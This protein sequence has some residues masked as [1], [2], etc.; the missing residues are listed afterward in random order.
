[1]TTLTEM[2]ASVMRHHA[3]RP[4]ILDGDLR[5]TWAAFGEHVARAAGVLLD[6]GIEPGT[7]FAIYARS[8][9]RFETLRWAGF[10][11]G[12]I[13]VMVNWRL[14]PPEVAHILADSNAALVAVDDAFAPAF[15]NEALAPWADRLL[16]MPDAYD[17]AVAR[18]KP[19]PAITGA[20]EDDDAILYYTGGTT[21]RSKGVRLSH[22][23]ILSNAVAFALGIGARHTDTYL[24]LAPSFHS[25]DLL[26]T[27]WI[28]QGAAQAYL[29][30]FSPAAF[31]DAIARYRVTATV[32]VPA[33]LMMTVT[34]PAFKEADLSSL[35]LLGYGAAPMA[36]EWIERVAKAFPD[37]AFL[38]CYG[39]TETAPDLTI[40]DPTE[41]RAA[42]AAGNRARLTS[43]GKPS[44][45]VQLRVVDDAGTDVP[46]GATGELWA[47]GPNITKGYLN[48][49]EMTE[50]AFVDG[51]FRTGDVAR[52]DEDGYVH[53]LDRVKDMVITGGENV[54]SSEVEAALHRHPDV[55]EAAVIGVPD[56]RMGEAL[57]A[58]IVPRPDS[59]PDEAT[60]IE[61]CRGLIAGYKI[62]RRMAFVDALPKSAMG[63]VLKT[64]L[65]ESYRNGS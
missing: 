36:I 57:L 44:A 17:A 7:R 39:L 63:K 4:A 29:A 50:A 6:H 42:I 52:F 1:M 3:K 49:P 45:I 25:A 38:N 14:A 41:F 47:K 28:V 24:H 12:A 46:E 65:R 27:S 8:G 40:F 56:D 15:Q 34:D 22:R 55:S 35:R 51:W 26:A 61:H 18:A 11:I 32:A 64:E 33:M 23:N 43:V 20:H 59:A 21:G 9:H 19:A 53:L 5:W 62:P 16:L 37:A 31:V 2:L 30:A 13:P 54:Y 58:V 60:L 10:R 48:L